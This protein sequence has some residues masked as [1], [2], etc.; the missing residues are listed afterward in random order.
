MMQ[1]RQLLVHLTRQV[2]E[3]TEQGARAVRARFREGAARIR[4]AA[5]AFTRAD[6]R[7]ATRVLEEDDIP[8]GETDFLGWDDRG[9][10]WAFT[11]DHVR[12]RLLRNYDGKPIGVQY[13]SKPFDSMV[14]KIWSRSKYRHTDFEYFIDDDVES[15]TM[16][17]KRRSPLREPPWVRISSDYQH[18]SPARVRTR[19]TWMRTRMVPPSSSESRPA[20]FLLR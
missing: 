17:F 18:F 20:G 3:A 1:A 19:C 10:V 2:A 11:P 7:Y 4:A 8:A 14:G 5:D 15:S 6:G 16:R 12:S 9:N 13:P